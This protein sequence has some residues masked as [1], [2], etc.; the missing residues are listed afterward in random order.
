MYY[1]GGR[2]LKGKHK[3]YREKDGYKP[4]WRFQSFIDLQNEWYAKLLSKG[5]TDIEYLHKISGAGQDTPFLTDHSLK[6][7]KTYSNETEF[8]FRS[9]RNFLMYGSF[10]SRQHKVLW[11]LH[12]EGYSY[13]QIIPMMNKRCKRSRSIFWISDHVNKIKKTMWIFNGND[14][15]GLR[16]ESDDDS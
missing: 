6:M 16:D 1:K 11:E 8:Y 12:C 10:P 15:E 4:Y 14:P 3:G 13:R 7:V 2:A 9:A 5:F